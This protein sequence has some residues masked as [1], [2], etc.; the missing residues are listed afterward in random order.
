MHEDKNPCRV[1]GLVPL[2]RANL[3]LQLMILIDSDASVHLGAQFG[4]I[5]RFVQALP[6]NAA[7][8]LAYALN[9]EA[10]IDRPFTTD[11]TA[12]SKALHVP[13]GPSAG[14]TSIYAS[15]SNLIAKW[16]GGAGQ[17]EVLLVSD[18]IDPTYGFFDTQPDQNPGLQRAIRD[19]QA[20]DVIVF[21]IFV[22]SG[23][24][25]RN[26]ILNLNGQGSLNE[27]TSGT[28]G[29]SFSQGTETPVSFR[30][31]LSELG[32]M[33]GAQYRLTFRPMASKSPGFHTL[34]VNTEVSGMKLLA[35]SRVYI[36][37][38]E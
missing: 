24:I 15:L 18:G 37:R 4:D 8:G 25:T 31:F 23:R 28:G 30:P 29:F 2:D 21:S 26:A 17:H 9:G 5:S 20:N 19:A 16:P 22:S 13:L 10:R 11:R 12:I 34:K 35:P 33:L 27:L 1:T 38:S 36:P 14:N 6:R 7:V 3:P 32:G